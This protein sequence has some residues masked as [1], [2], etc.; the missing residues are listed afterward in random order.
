MINPNGSLI[1]I[2]YS[3]NMIVPCVHVARC[4]PRSS[5]NMNDAMNIESDDN[6]NTVFNDVFVEI[7][8]YNV[9]ESTFSSALITKSLFTMAS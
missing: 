1:L 5:A 7:S 9:L 8:K 2:F 4:Q 6:G 3:S